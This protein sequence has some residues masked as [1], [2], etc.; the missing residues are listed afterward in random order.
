MSIL[1][2]EAPKRFGAKLGLAFLFALAVTALSTGSAHAAP[3]HQKQT[4][5]VGPQEYSQQRYLNQ[6]SGDWS[7]S[8]RFVFEKPIT[9]D[10]VVHRVIVPERGYAELL[11]RYVDEPEFSRPKDIPADVP[12]SPYRR[13]TLQTVNALKQLELS[14]GEFKKGVILT[15]TGW[16]ATRIQAPYSEMLVDEITFPETQRTVQLHERNYC[17]VKYQEKDQVREELSQIEGVPEG[18]R[19]PTPFGGELA[20][21]SAPSDT[22]SK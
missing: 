4:P 8:D 21:D 13:A 6:S 15:I 10:V 1:F 11:Y 16:P 14:E 12:I 18:F 17:M 22:I 3:K 9:R 2:F 19:C 20:A 7:Q 5:A